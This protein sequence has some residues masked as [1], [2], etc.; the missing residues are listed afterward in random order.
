MMKKV[1][2][3]DLHCKKCKKLTTHIPKMDAMK[4]GKQVCSECRTENKNF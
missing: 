3:K 1:K 4:N 2:F